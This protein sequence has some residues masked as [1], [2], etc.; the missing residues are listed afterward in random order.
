MLQVRTLGGLRLTS[1]GRS[2][3]RKPLALLTYVARRGARGVTRTELATLFWGERGEERARQSL[4]QALLELKQV[5]GDKVEVDADS[6]RIAVTAVELDVAAFEHELSD[7]RVQEAVAR[8]TG[9]FFEGAEDIGGDGFR[10]WIENERAALHQ[11]LGVAMG[12]LIGD[13]ELSGDWIGATAWAQQWAAALP[14]DEQAHLRLIEALRMSGRNA[15]ALKTHAAYVTRVRAALD[16][17][18]SS[19]F[20]RLGGG[21]AEGARGQAVRRSRGSAAVHAPEL[22]ARGPVLNELLDA[23]TQAAGGEP[24]VVLIE[25]TT[26][27]GLTRTCD[28]LVAAVRADATVF[29][30][31]GASPATDLATAAEL[32][33]GIRSAEGSAGAAPEALGE[34][35]RL[36]PALTSEFQSLPPATGD[37]AALC[38]ALVQTLAA[39][40]DER[41]VL[42]VVDDA[43]AA[44]AA[45]R[46]LLASLATRL[47]G[48]VMLVMASDEGE[49]QRGAALTTLLGTTG[50]RHL[51]LAELGVAEVEAMLESMV[52]IGPSDR[53]ALAARLHE[54]TGG[55]PHDI[56]EVVTSLV[57][58]HLLTPDAT[59]AWHVS[60]ALAGRALPI[61]SPLRERMRAR[62]DRR[63][64]AAQQ[65]AGAM[66]V[67]VPPVDASVA[68]EMCGLSRDDGEVALRELA[69]RRVVLE[70]PTQPG[71][72]AFASPLAGRVVA[73]LLPA[74][75]RE[76]LHERAAQILSHRDLA[77]TAERSLLP[78][79]LARAPRPAAAPPVIRQR[80]RA[81]W[82][83]PRVIVPV[84]GVVIAGAIVLRG[85]L[86]LRATSSDPDVPIIALGRIADYRERTTTPVTK[87]LSDM[88]ATN[89]GRVGR[90]RVVSA[91]RMYEL[92]SRSGPPGDTSDAAL[93]RAARRAGATE[94]VDGALYSRDDGGFR[95]DLRRVEVASGNIRGTHSVTGT[96]LFELADSG[97]ARM[98]ADFGETTPV[99]SIADVTTR[100]VT[101]YRLYEQG[102]RAFYANDLRGAEPLFEAALREDS[103]FAM[104]A[105]YS[106][107]S[108]VDDP[109]LALA[110]YRQAAR[111]ATGT[112]NRERLTILA[113]EAY[114][115]SSPALGAIAD[116]LLVRYPD[117]VE[118]YYFSGLSRLVEG[119]FLRAI[120]PLNRAVAMDSLS[121]GGANAR[122][123]ACEALRQIISAYQHADSLA[124]AER[125]ARR[126]VRLQPNSPA[127]WHTLADVLSQR[128]RFA[129]VLEVLDRQATLDGGRDETYRL[130][131]LAVHRMYAGDFEQVD[132]LIDAELESGAPVRSGRAMWYRVISYR[133]Q[134]RL[135]EAL[136]AA[137][138][139]RENGMK[140]YRR[141][142]RV[143]RGA[144]PPEAIAEAQ[145]L[146]E[147]GRYRES[148]ALYD[149]IARW[150]VD[151]SPSQLAHATAWAMTHA[152]G[153]L[154]AAGD[155]AG[156]AARAD[157]VR[158]L[159][160]QSYLGRDKL[161]HH[162]IRGV[163]LVARGQDEAAIAELYR[164]VWSWN[165][166]YTRTNMVLAAALMRRERAREAITVL[167]PGLRGYVEASNY[168][169]SRTDIHE[170]LAQGW[171]AVSGA[172][173][174][175]SATAHYAFVARAWRRADPAFANR[176]QTATRL[177]GGAASAR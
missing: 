139:H 155:T 96:T 170:M 137:K 100:S 174:R 54:E 143:P 23:W 52:A 156:L 15:D 53:H 93:V 26:G 58:E 136:D 166:G 16:V 79:H 70:I 13:A 36:V 95:L 172:A 30:A 4:R 6:V 50:L 39:I 119:A 129:E 135:V 20:L 29:R 60:P 24:A 45:S 157:S 112:S 121:L 9:D 150:G 3:R 63:S 72:Y 108:V 107:R 44:D 115:A 64:A 104:A 140:T 73:A 169:V 111:L 148:A 158:A 97:T 176:I 159:G 77:S 75:Q 114:L 106:A 27:S 153:G 163:L 46:G 38:D 91:A 43:H 162:Y 11:Q 152:A 123:D 177:S 78:Y 69:E 171:S 144:A 42:V 89:L 22:I 109:Y 154:A 146:Y 71:R 161:L 165:V 131:N 142:I 128:G 76:T 61:P 102:L 17:E 55:L 8:W 41:P 81:W 88:L 116:T 18:P 25:G 147:M 134:G 103:T 59:G 12:K 74:S 151:E 141:G 1:E 94:L 33:D 99:G 130:L 66:S 101:A 90:L 124:A 105:Y 35:T 32:F 28:E 92:V 110:R 2:L 86:P 167:Q 49:R 67:L 120:P 85:G 132:R 62:L 80:A 84:A 145:V 125:E 122:C 126:W 56:R 118:G 31:R 48:C 138:R 98:A 51:R 164:A 83:S 87:P 57:D 168:Y 14:F 133:Q 149:S 47:T 19:E 68:A 160:A 5:L 37:D 40:G 127:P 34:I 173:A 10:R 82:K 175:D 117:E 21:L 7:G 65:L 113:R